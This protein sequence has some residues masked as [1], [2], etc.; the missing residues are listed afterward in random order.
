MK[1]LKVL[2]LDENCDPQLIPVSDLLRGMGEPR[3]EADKA[4]E[5]PSLCA[6][7]WEVSHNTIQVSLRAKG[8]ARPLRLQP[9]LKK[10]LLACCVH[11]VLGECVSPEELAEMKGPDYVVTAIYARIA[12]IRRAIDKL[13]LGIRGQAVLQTFEG[14]YR[15]APEVEIVFPLSLTTADPLRYYCFLR[16]SALRRRFEHR[17]GAVEKFERFARERGLGHLLDQ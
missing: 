14:G 1:R 16:G 6:L 13:G 4:A 10:C 12:E 8:R 15:V 3:A 9:V 2:C 11:S 17:P 5:T 7:V